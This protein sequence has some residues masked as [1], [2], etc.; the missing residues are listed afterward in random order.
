MKMAALLL[1]LRAL[2]LAQQIAIGSYAAPTQDSGPD[3]ITQGPDGA[4][5]F[6]EG[7]NISQI[8][9]IS[10]AGAITQYTHPTVSTTS[11]ITAGPDGA[12]WFTEWAG[13]IGR[14]TTA[15]AITEYPVPTPDSGSSTIAA[16]PDGALWFTESYTNKIG[17]ITTAGAF[18]EYP[19]P[20]ANS[21]PFGIAAGSDGALWFCENE[22]NQIG[23]VTTAGAFTEYRVPTANSKLNWI[24]AGPDGALW[25]VEHRG[26]IGRITTEGVIAE[27]P[28]SPGPYE[29][30][31]GPDGALWFTL[32]NKIGRIT[33][34]GVAT[35]YPLPTAG[36]VPYGIT[37]GPDGALWI[38]EYGHNA[39][40]EVVFVTAN[41]SVTPDSGVYQSN[42][43]FTGSGFAPGESVQIY[44]GGIGSAVVA[45]G[46]ADAGGSI[47]AAGIVPDS[48]YGPRIFL[49]VGQSSGKLG[50][51][52]FSMTPRVIMS[53]NSGPVGSYTTPNGVGFPSFAP[54]RIY[55]NNPRTFLGEIFADYRGTLTGI[56]TFQFLVPS[57]APQG[58][59]EVI[60]QEQGG[61]PTA[62]GYFTVQ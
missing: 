8:G 35:E 3:V 22:A 41:L 14:S 2:S 42:L 44:S 62:L 51:A 17:R 39:I 55:W 56:S 37:A 47:S 10:P 9:R 32:A 59:N 49:G 4:L 25:F 13:V 50:A 20:T 53:P 26:N 34:A 36:N 19:I 30:A 46:T 43:S 23:R 18:T 12:L 5:W 54:V 40:G 15:G 45:S 7:D 1:I 58:E 11:G 21:Y 24:T 48:V 60:G 61:T 33:T 27:Y 57:G 16:G 28:V 38:A 31:V 29:I 6:T 52:D